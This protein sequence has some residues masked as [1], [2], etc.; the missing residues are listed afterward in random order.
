MKKTLF[1]IVTLVLTGFKP[2]VESPYRWEEPAQC[3]DSLDITLYEYYIVLPEI[4]SLQI[5]KFISGDVYKCSDMY[6]SDFDPMSE[7]L[8]G[9]Y[10]VT[11]DSIDFYETGLKYIFELPEIY[12]EYIDNFGDRQC[13]L[14]TINYV[15]SGKNN[16]RGDNVSTGIVHNFGESIIVPSFDSFGNKHNVKFCYIPGKKLFSEGVIHP[17]EM[18]PGVYWQD[19]TYPYLMYNDYSKLDGKF[20][21]FPWAPQAFRWRKGKFK[22]CD[23]KRVGTVTTRIDVEKDSLLFRVVN[24]RCYLRNSGLKLYSKRNEKKLTAWMST[25]REGDSISLEL[26][27]PAYPRDSVAHIAPLCTGSDTIYAAYGEAYGYFFA[28][29]IKD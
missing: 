9:I 18:F 13:G 20:E 24:P 28:K 2:V 12:N 6:K 19:Y 14:R 16:G 8:D 3:G 5:V 26:I 29:R 23:V 22:V 15:P 27:R 11:S 25:V 1:I 21:W 17:K 4:T 7:M 10:Q